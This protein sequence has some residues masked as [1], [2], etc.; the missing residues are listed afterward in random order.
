MIT[1]SVAS[2]ARTHKTCTGYKS[3]ASHNFSYNYQKNFN[4]HQLQFEPIRH[5]IGAYKIDN[6]LLLGHT[7]YDRRN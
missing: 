4:F 1:D 7:N 5:I 2:V 6:K 3:L